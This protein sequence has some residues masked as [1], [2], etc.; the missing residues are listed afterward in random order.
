[1]NSEEKKLT[2]YSRGS[3]CGCKIAPADLESILT[4]SGAAAHFDA[5]IIGNDS[6]DDAAVVDWGD[7]SALISTTDF[8]QPI[9]D[10]PYDFG[11]IAAINAISDVYAMGGHPIVAVAI[12]GWPVEKLGHAMAAKVIE[13]GRAACEDEGIALGG[14][15]SIDA[16][17]PFFGLAVN[18]RVRKDQIK[19]NTGAQVGDRLFLSKPLGTG[20][21]SAAAKRGVAQADHLEFAIKTMKQSNKLGGQLGHLDTVH[22]IT[23]VTGFG[24]LGHLIE[25]CEGSGVSAEL[26]F[27]NVPVFPDGMLDG[28]LAQFIMPDNTMRNF[29]A[30]SDNCNTLTANQLQVLCDPQTSGGLLIS[31]SEDLT[32]KFPQLVEI[33]AI[34]EKANPLVTVA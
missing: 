31:S 29:K 25:M 22:A 16:Q 6:R 1:M 13:G 7:G 34:V 18:G 12:L 20:I 33:G 21:I 27:E 24:L 10:D 5:L 8:F 4:Q 32:S 15:H 3:G 2:S 28:Y 17:E 14:G 23:D 26:N 9:V 19:A 30:S 11:Y